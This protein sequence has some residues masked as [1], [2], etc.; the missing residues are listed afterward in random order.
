MEKITHSA[1]L[2]SMIMAL[3]NQQHTEYLVLKTE[4]LQE[5]QK[6]KPINIIKNTLAQIIATPDLAKDLIKGTILFIISTVFSKFFAKKLDTPVM[7]LLGIVVEMVILNVIAKR[8][9]KQS[10]KDELISTK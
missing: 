10:L 9:E 4:L 5:G 2:K 8:L 6:L 1:N 3:E 7:K